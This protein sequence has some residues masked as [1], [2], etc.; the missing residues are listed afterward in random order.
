[1]HT[2]NEKVTYSQRTWD[3]FQKSLS[4]A[5]QDK[6][7]HRKFARLNPDLNGSGVVL[8]SLDDVEGLIRMES[9]TEKEYIPMNK[10]RLQEVANTLVAS[11]FFFEGSSVARDERIGD[12]VVKGASISHSTSR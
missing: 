2:M 10:E 5:A 9:Y 4:T 7:R 8:P 3:D 6:D 11:L 1:M 12:F